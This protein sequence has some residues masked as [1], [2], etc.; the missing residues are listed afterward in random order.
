MH[1]SV[2]GLFLKEILSEK[3]Q[4]NMIKSYI[5]KMKE[6]KKEKKRG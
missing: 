1:W 6:D 4:L 3:Q 5:R 2:D